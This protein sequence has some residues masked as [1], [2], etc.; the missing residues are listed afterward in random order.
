MN[1]MR[2]LF[3]FVVAAILASAVSPVGAATKQFNLTLSAPSGGVVTATFNNLSSGNSVIKSESLT[4]PTG[5]SIASATTVAPFAGVVTTT[6]APAFPCATIQVNY[7]SGIP[8]STSAS[9]LLTVSS[10]SIA[11]CSQSAPWTVF[12]WTGN[13]LGGSPFSYTGAAPT[14]IN[15]T[16]CSLGFLKQPANAQVNAKITSVPENPLGAP[17]QV[18]LLSAPNTVATFFTGQITLTN[19]GPGLGTLT[20]SGP[21]SAVNGVATFP[22]LALNAAGNYTLAASSSG[23]TSVNS[24]PFIIYSGILDCGDDLLSTFTNPY[25]VAP[26]QPG[27][28]NGSRGL[29]NKDGSTC[30]KVPYTFTNTILTDDQVHLSWDTSIQA[31]PAFM[32]SLNWRLRSVEPPTIPVNVINPLAGWTTAPRPQVAW[33]A[34]GSGNPV[35]VPGL[36]CVSGKLPAPYGTLQTGIAANATKVT[37]TGIAANPA[38]PYAV[39]APGAPAV[40]PV[41]F[42]IVIANT[43]GGAPAAGV[44]RMTAVSIDGSPVLSAGTYTITYNVSRG[45]VTE[46]MSQP[47][48]HTAGYRVM[49]TP[50]PIIPNDATTFPLPYVAQTQAN[51]CIA[52]HGFDSFGIGADGVARLLYFTTVIDIGDGWVRVSQ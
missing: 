11:G 32:Y 16:G 43:I 24:N 37:I 7:Q 17:V 21:I 18:A 20:G 26:D 42:P 39:P 40:P 13:N 50:L 34:D 38:S 49:S 10:P 31:N 33:L 30:I 46:G 15:L 6:C 45:G 44:E 27:Y 29:Y 8:G 3:G 22:S 41:P 12:A 36:A 9:V 4:A 25:N 19:A 2:N 14:A 48:E 23:L 51:M 52:Q 35:F 28:S 1:R 5:Y 47:A